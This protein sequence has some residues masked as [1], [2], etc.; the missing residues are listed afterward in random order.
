VGGRAELNHPLSVL[1]FTDPACPWAWGSEPTFG[2]LRWALAGQ[3]SWRRVFGILFDPAE[4]D[5][6]PDPAAEARWY[7]RF[8]DDVC[9]HTGAPAAR[10]LEW[11]CLDSWPASL[12]ATAALAQGDELADRVLRRLRE[13]TFVRGRPADTDPAVRAALSG[14]PG[15][16]LDRL[17]RDA[18][19][20][21]V[22]ARVQADR[23]LTR[24]PGPEVFD[25]DR[26]GPAAGPHPGAAKEVPGGHRYALPTLVLQ[27][28]A[29]RAVVPGWRPLEQYVDAVLR[30]APGVV[31]NHRLPPAA[32]VLARRRTLTAPE[33]LQLTDDKHAP[34][35]ALEL[36]LRHGPLWVH[37][38]E[39]N[40]DRIYRQLT[41]SIEDETVIP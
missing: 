12:A 29:G 21:E 38:D 8:V 27:G 32:L 10:R 23:A 40:L 9:R 34:A 24:S 13:Q 19:S 35:T 2:W 1:E 36:Q 33:L 16:D 14:L 41:D 26:V 30:V 28:P 4:D 15:L 5:A 37:P 39:R 25:P 7:Q 18:A 20:D 11:V 31:L 6:A 22:R 3:V 17:V